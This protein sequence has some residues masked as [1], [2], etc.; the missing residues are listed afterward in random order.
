MST[1][2]IL[3]TILITSA[4]TASVSGFTSPLAHDYG[5]VQWLP[6]TETVEQGFVSGPGY[7]DAVAND[8]RTTPAQF[9]KRLQELPEDARMG[10]L[11]ELRVGLRL[12]AEGAEARGAWD[13]GARLQ[14]IPAPQLDLR[15]P[16][17][18]RG[19]HTWPE[20]DVWLPVADAYAQSFTS[21]YANLS[22]ITVRVATFGGDLI[23]GDATI[24][25]GGGELL[26]LPI[27]GDSIV[28][29]DAG[30]RVRVMSA[31][32][33]WAQ[34]QLPSGLTGFAPLTD[35]ATL[36]QPVRRP[37]DVLFTLRDESGTI[38]QE[39][40]VP[41]DSIHDNAHLT[42][43]FDPIPASG[44]QSYTF[45]FVPTDA[46]LDAFTLRAT[47]DDDYRDGARSDDD[48]TDL[49]FQPE[50]DESSPLIDLP[51]DALPRDDEW[52][53]VAN[54][55]TVPSAIAVALR[56]VPGD[57]DDPDQLQFG[58]TSDRAPYGATRATDA[59]GAALPGA[60]LVMTI[61]ERDV[62]IQALFGDGLSNL[63]EAAG[64][65]PLMV[66]IYVTLLIAAGAILVKQW[67]VLFPRKR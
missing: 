13:T 30:E 23:P 47:G 42:I 40:I 1:L 55:S 16:E 29:L 31:S 4:C 7:A 3:L 25:P 33:G 37:S 12:M 6:L 51:V 65:D 39:V 36:P 58:V 9:Q 50:Y 53:I 19:F 38:V 45:E 2:L 35:F 34:A 26:A 62:N 44:G 18:Q 14:I 17:R 66:A 59:S 15:F 52:V 32:E 64:A 67:H 24:G 48:M 21:P 20:S 46:S 57:R 8:A 22:G 61:W 11:T 49:V 43:A 60:L 28:S 63:I 27:D 41:A 10:E 54:P 56:L 5:I